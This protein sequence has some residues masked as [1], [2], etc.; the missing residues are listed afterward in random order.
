MSHNVQYSCNQRFHRNGSR[1]K[2]QT[3]CRDPFLRGKGDCYLGE[4]AWPFEGLY[5]RLLTEYCT[6]QSV[7]SKVKIL[8]QRID[9]PFETTE[10]LDARNLPVGISSRECSFALSVPLGP[11]DLNSSPQFSDPDIGQFIDGYTRIMCVRYFTN[12]TPSNREARELVARFNPAYPT[13]TMKP[14]GAWHTTESRYHKFNFNFGP[15]GRSLSREYEHPTLANV[16]AVPSVVVA[17]AVGPA[18]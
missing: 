4:V 6:F 8:I 15:R 7:Q 10:K 2:P 9:V 14:G 17:H 12:E 3:L 13:D 18:E 11:T 1:R 5:L 16:H